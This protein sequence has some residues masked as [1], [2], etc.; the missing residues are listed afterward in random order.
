MKIKRGSI[1]EKI[2]VNTMAIFSQKVFADGTDDGKG[3]DSKSEGNDG[4]DD[5]SGSDDSKGGDDST[6][7]EGDDGKTKSKSD[8]TPPNFEDLMTRARREEREK[9]YPQ[10]NKL[11]EEKNSLLLSEEK[12]KQ[13]VESLEKE[14]KDLKESSNKSDD[15]K[16]SALNKEIDA[17]KKELEDVEGSKVDENELRKNI[18]EEIRG[19]YDTKL[20]R[21]QRLREISDEGKNVIPELVM[22]NTKEEIDESIKLAEKRYE[23]IVKREIGNIEMPKGN[24][25]S[26]STNSAIKDVTPSDIRNMS[27]EEYAEYRKKLNLK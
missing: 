14:N 6:N 15:E 21:E 9:L 23:E 8:D 5:K 12:L 13:K 7:T 3:D 20:Y 2:M 1:L 4:K 17:L 16:V 25:N 22:G 26:G 11:K 27:N 10:I 18:E 24:S 19:E